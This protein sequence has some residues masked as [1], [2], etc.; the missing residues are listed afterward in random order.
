M[1]NLSHQPPLRLHTSR[2]RCIE[3]T[4]GGI[5]TSRPAAMGAARV[6]RREEDM[7]YG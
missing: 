7:S 3:M 5:V 4:W 6:Q 1:V 2:S